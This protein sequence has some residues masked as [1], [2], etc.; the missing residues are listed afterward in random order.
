MAGWRRTVLESSENFNKT[1]ASSSFCGRLSYMIPCIHGFAVLLYAVA[2]KQHEEEVKLQYRKK[3]SCNTYTLRQ[4]SGAI[5]PSAEACKTG[6]D[7]ED[8]KAHQTQRSATSG[9]CSLG[10]DPWG[11]SAPR[12]AAAGTLEAQQFWT[13]ACT[14]RQRHCARRIARVG[15]AQLGPGPTQWQE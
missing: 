12:F 9:N 1:S 13:V 11:A 6:G 5:R 8:W 3:S 7:S 14:L 10:M 4:A 15:Q 2:L